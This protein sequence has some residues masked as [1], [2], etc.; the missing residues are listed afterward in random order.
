[1][2]VYSVEWRKVDLDLSELAKLRW[3]QNKTI[4]ELAK[5][6]ERQPKTI[7]FHLNRLKVKKTIKGQSKP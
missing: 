6:F 4:A 3:K 5:R 1:M 7:R 2:E